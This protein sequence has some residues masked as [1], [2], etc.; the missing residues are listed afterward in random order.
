MSVGNQDITTVATYWPEMAEAVF[1]PHTEDE[2][3]RLVALLDGLIDEVGED[4]AHPLASLM[5]IL[6]VLI[7]KYEEENVPE[8]TS[9][10]G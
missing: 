4:E 7:E 6:G 1:V 2:Y 5:E 3:S 8:L 9:E 10:E